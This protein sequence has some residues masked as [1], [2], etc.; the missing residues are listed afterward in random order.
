MDS[1]YAAIGF[2]T[3]WPT[4]VRAAV[5]DGDTNIDV[6]WRARKAGNVID[7]HELVPEVL[8]DNMD[9]PRVH[10][11]CIVDRRREWLVVKGRAVIDPRI[12]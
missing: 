1:V 12:I 5:V 2:M 8:L 4:V 6:T 9:D 3:G 10:V 7:I 11:E